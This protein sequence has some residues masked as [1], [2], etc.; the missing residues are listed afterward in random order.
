M[1]MKPATRNFAIAL[2]IALTAAAATAQTV[3]KG[4]SN[5]S[6]YGTFAYTSSGLLTAPPALAGPFG[7]VGA[8]NFDGNGNT[9]ATAWTSQNG[10]IAQV[11]IKGTYTVNPDC[12]GTM[13][14]SVSVIN[15]PMA[16]PPG[17]YF[18]VLDNTA[19]EFQAVS[20]SPAQ[21]LTAFGKL[22]FQ[23]YGDPRR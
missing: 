1:M 12:T 13:T 9:T 7:S 17:Q 23:G 18:F 14:L 20:L 15:P 2:T 19:T 21:V 5:A 6:L 22:Q 4:C 10:N 11:T 3:N 16:L 8:Q